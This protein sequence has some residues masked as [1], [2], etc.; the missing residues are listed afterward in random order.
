MVL[1]VTVFAC[2]S[3][4][5]RYQQVTVNSDTIHSVHRT[6]NCAATSGSWEQKNKIL[7]WNSNITWQLVWMIDKE[8][9]EVSDRELGGGGGGE[10]R[11]CEKTSTE[12]DRFYKRTQPCSSMIAHPSSVMIIVR[13]ASLNWP[14]CVL[15]FQFPMGLYTQLSPWLPASFQ[16]CL[17]HLLQRLRLC[18]H[19]QLLPTPRL[20]STVCWTNCCR[21]GSLRNLRSLTR[22]LRRKRLPHSQK[23]Q[24]LWS[25]RNQ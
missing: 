21:L 19:L 20:T 1:C 15:S 14:L 7:K 22:P 12:T 24:L 25:R 4:R 23:L 10:N 6:E 18:L 2:W 11:V 8:I 9:T 3:W 17:S 13:L 16:A 5:H